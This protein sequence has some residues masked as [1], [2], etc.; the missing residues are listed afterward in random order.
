MKK[1][2]VL[3]GAAVCVFA[4]VTVTA[5]SRYTRY[6]QSGGSSE[7]YTRIG[8][9]T[10]GASC[11]PPNYC[12]YAGVAIASPASAPDM[13]RALKN[14]S[15]FYDM[16]LPSPSGNQ[17]PI[18]RCTDQATEPAGNA[19]GNYSK[20][21]GLGGAGGAEQLWNTDSTLLHINTSQGQ[22]RIIPFNPATMTCGAAI[23][24]NK[25]QDVSNPG[26]ALGNSTTTYGFG[27]GSF[28]WN[29]RQIYYGMGGTSQLPGYIVS[30]YTI[31][32]TDS[33]FTRLSRWVDMSYGYP[34]NDLAP[35]WTPGTAY[36]KGAYV[37]YTFTLPDWNGTTS[38]VV[39]DLI[40][41]TS[42][43]QFNCAFKLITAG[44]RGTQPTWSV[45]NDGGC[46]AYQIRTEGGGTAKWQNIGNTGTFTYQL[47]SAGGTSSTPGPPAFMPANGHPDMGTTVTDGP[48][49]WTNTGPLNPQN[50]SSF[51]GVSKDSKRVCAAYSSNSYGTAARGYANDMA[52]QDTGIYVECYDSTSN[53]FVLLNTLTGIQSQVTCAG[54]SD[55]ACTGGTRSMSMQGTTPLNVITSCGLALHNAKGGSTLDVVVFGFA[56]GRTFGSC[57]FNSGAPFYWKPFAAYGSSSTLRVINTVSNHFAVGK[58]KYVNWGA[59]GM[60]FGWD[61]GAYNIIFDSTTDFSGIGKS[62]WQVSPCD[63]NWAIGS[64]LPSCTYPEV[65]DAHPAFLHGAADDDTGPTCSTVFGTTL[66]PYSLAPYQNEVVCASSSPM[67]TPGVD[68]IGAAAKTWRF[69]HTFNGGGNPFFDVQFAIGQLSQ[70]GKFYAFSSD[71]MCSLGD[72]SGN[73]TNI[74]GY[75]WVPGHSYSVG[76]RVNPM[77]SSTGSGT[78]YGVY[79]VTVGG[80]AAASK[81]TW[82][83][84]TSGNV[85]TTVTD[86]NGLVYSCL[87]PNNAK[88]EV[89]VVGLR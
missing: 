89:F 29:D 59:T 71:W 53:T 39:G 10:A 18:V 15:V 49:T 22:G 62:S 17:S 58:E 19:S 41:P 11:V 44:T 6:G 68:A 73:S 30:K 76:D 33:T 12:A 66:S 7:G 27:G 23:T 35:A 74:C 67:W 52:N 55:Y 56:P 75:P 16:S 37:S 36:S 81:P 24:A 83:G 4:A 26:V 3:I 51:A 86:A 48:L 1:S 57:S 78:N 5:Q 70:D 21:V 77:G 20:S 54:A 14:G 69:T 82:I 65:I 28:D 45:A 31:N 88:G 13:G 87:G 84:C 42:G 47:I 2:G 50:W 25:G 40:K 38:P 63:A 34:V 85:G 8:G 46:L 43:N 61:S 79:E 80:I 64:I 32:P 72:T 60:N 9:A